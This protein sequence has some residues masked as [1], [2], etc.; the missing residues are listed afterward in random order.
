MNVVAETRSKPNL[1]T[2]DNVN[3]NDWLQEKEKEN[4]TSNTLAAIPN[5]LLANTPSGLLH[6]PEQ[7]PMFFPAFVIETNWP[8]VYGKS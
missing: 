5:A 6:D 7:I 3:L 4:H 1:I 2:G 8:V